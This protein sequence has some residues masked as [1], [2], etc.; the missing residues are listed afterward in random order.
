MSVRKTPELTYDLVDSLF[1]CDPGEGKVYSKVNRGSVKIDDECGVIIYNLNRRIPQKYWKINFS[2]NGVR[3]REKR[4]KIIF[5]L[6]FKRLPNKGLVLDHINGDSLDDSILNLQEII[7]GLNCIK[8]VN[9]NRK[10]LLPR[11]VYYEHEKYVVKIS[12]NKKWI[13]RKS[14][15][16]LEEATID[17]QRVRDEFNQT[18]FSN[19]IYDIPEIG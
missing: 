11:N 2:E 12:R 19:F 16:N 1:Y 18:N 5:I 13:Y 4:S 3:Y 15:E 8:S 6:V 9:Y 10:H 7:Y 17:A 14:W